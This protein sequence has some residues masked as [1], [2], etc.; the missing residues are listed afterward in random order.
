MG[1]LRRQSYNGDADQLN[2]SHLHPSQHLRHGS[3]AVLRDR[4]RLRVTIAQT[5]TEDEYGDRDL[6]KGNVGKIDS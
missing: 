2:S 1:T 6:W 3:C 4:H 5:Y